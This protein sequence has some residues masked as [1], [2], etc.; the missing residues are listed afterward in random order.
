MTDED[1]KTLAIEI[2][3]RDSIQRSVAPRWEKE[4]GWDC[5]NTM[6]INLAQRDGEP[7]ID[8]DQKE[9]LFLYLMKGKQ[10]VAYAKI[11]LNL[12]DLMSES[13]QLQQWVVFR[14][15]PT[16]DYFDDDYKCGL[17]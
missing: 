10:H 2:R 3:F 14:K 13:K 6:M 16:Q 9:F 17:L 15:E 8:L 12:N 11:P 7:K 4:Q 5:K 1:R